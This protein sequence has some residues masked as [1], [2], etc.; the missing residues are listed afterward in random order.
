MDCKQCGGLGWVWVLDVIS[1]AMNREKCL[2]CNG[3]GVHD[4]SK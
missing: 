3:T 4:D 2:L 1:H